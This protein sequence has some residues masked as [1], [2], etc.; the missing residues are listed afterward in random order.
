MAHTLFITGL[1][2]IGL[3]T[4]VDLVTMRSVSRSTM[5]LLLVSMVHALKLKRYRT[6]SVSMNVCCRRMSPP[7]LR[8]G[9]RAGDSDTQ[10][11]HLHELPRHEQ[12]PRLGRQRRAED[13]HSRRRA[14]PAPAARSGSVTGAFGFRRAHDRRP[15][16]PPLLRLGLSPSSLFP[17]AIRNTVAPMSTRT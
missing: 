14:C 12:L 2:C 17:C 7:S 4:L 3:C 1:P 16:F 10:P 6:F 15:L 8:F 9:K 5:L 13:H 11:G